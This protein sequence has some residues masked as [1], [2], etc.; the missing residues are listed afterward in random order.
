M[1]SEPNLVQPESAG[2]LASAETKMTSEPNLVQPE[3]ARELA[4]A[5]TKMTSEPN[6]VQ[7]ES[8]GE[9]AS[10]EKKMTSEPNLV[11]P[12]SAGELGLVETQATARDS[13]WVAGVELAQRASPRR[14]RRPR[15]RAKIEPVEPKPVSELASAETKMTSKPNLARSERVVE[16]GKKEENSREDVSPTNGVEV[17]P[18]SGQ[19]L[20]VGRRVDLKSWMH[21][22]RGL[23]FR[24]RKHVRQRTT[25]TRSPTGSFLPRSADNGHR[26]AAGEK[27]H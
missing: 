19:S 2:E 22:R 1:T 13:Q 11:Q 6:L 17:K 26:A 8:A 9:L 16:P 25:H 7:P 10:A 15:P 23:R 14:R 4:S 12:E 21:G 18:G 5:E 20:A 3:S 24:R 27:L